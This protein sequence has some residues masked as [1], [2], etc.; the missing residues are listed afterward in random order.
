[1]DVFLTSITA[2]LPHIRSGKLRGL[3]VSSLER[4]P[5]I[6]ELPTIAE[7][8]L[9]GYEADGWKG[10]LAPARTPPAVV[11]RLNDAVSRLLKAPDVKERMISSGQVPVSSTPEA[12]AAFVKAEVEKWATIIKQ[13]AIKG[14]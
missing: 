3:A 8:G 1:V 5:L 2:G 7:S 9:P 14:D 4:S 12:F 10:L 6:P 13:A 11:A